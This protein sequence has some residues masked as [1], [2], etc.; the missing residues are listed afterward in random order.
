MFDF[1]IV[2]I[3]TPSYAHSWL[4]KNEFQDSSDLF[5]LSGG[6]TTKY[7]DIEIGPMKPSARTSFPEDYKYLSI[8]LRF[9]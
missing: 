8:D 6:K 9:S 5:N 4:R 2:N 7:Q 1:R 3:N